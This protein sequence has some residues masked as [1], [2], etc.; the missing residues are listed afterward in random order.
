MSHPGCTLSKFLTH[1]THEHNKLV[2]DLCYQ[3]S[4]GFVRQQL[5][6]VTPSLGL[7]ICSFLSLECYSLCSSS[8]PFESCLK[9]HLLREVS[10][11]YQCKVS[12]FICLRVPVFLLQSIHKHL[13]VFNYLFLLFSFCLLHDTIHFLRA[14][15]T[16]HLFTLQRI[17][18][19]CSY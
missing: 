12:P 18:S 11:D 3:V 14:G 13:T 9:H 2:A 17:W 15:T 5:T 16:F 8:T 6:P 19:M 7:H 4:G 1:R 10:S